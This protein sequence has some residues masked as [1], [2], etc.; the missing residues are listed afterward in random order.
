MSDTEVRL[1]L[2]DISA[3]LSFLHSEARMVHLGI[4][5]ENVYISPT[6]KWKVAG[7]ISSLPMANESSVDVNTTDIIHSARSQTFTDASA[8]I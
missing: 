1:G 6:G 3:A 2:L 8:P 7:L 5:P 4:S